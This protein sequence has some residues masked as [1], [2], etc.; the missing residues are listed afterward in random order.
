M[1]KKTANLKNIGIL[2]SSLG[3]LL[4]ILNTSDSDYSLPLSIL[5]AV[6]AIA[7][8]VLIVRAD[9]QE[10]NAK[11]SSLEPTDKAPGPSDQ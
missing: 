7:G 6:L 4:V 1:S 8:L 2:L 10:K 3:G 5:A 9:R 11:D